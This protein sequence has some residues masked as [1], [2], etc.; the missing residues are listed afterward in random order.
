M[1]K[2]LLPPNATTLER[3]VASTTGRIDT[4]TTPLREV[5]NPAT[6]PV[7]VLPWL[8][9]AFGVEDWSSRWT[10]GQR[11]AVIE[12]SI[13][14]KRHRGTIGA[15]RSAIAA[16]DVT[17]RVQ[18]WFNQNPPGD[19]YTFRLLID[20]DQVGIEQSMYGALLA[21]IERNKNLRSHL[22]RIDL[23]VQTTGATS[24]ACSA[25]IGHEISLTN[26]V[27]PVVVMNETTICI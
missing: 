11:R 20:V 24:V 4:L 18:E 17:C 13:P 27:W 7:H 12:K 19:E 14:V 10:R 23:T 25:G 6:C 22:S 26:Y 1:T 21:L 8:A 5:W 9:Y 15:V 3:A 2:S 16:L